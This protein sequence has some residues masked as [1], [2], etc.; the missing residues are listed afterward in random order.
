MQRQDGV[1]RMPGFRFL[2]AGRLALEAFS[3]EADFTLSR[4]LMGLNIATSKLLGFRR[5]GVELREHL[6]MLNG[7]LESLFQAC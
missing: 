2:K 6:G 5:V 4:A 1:P 7:G 3:L